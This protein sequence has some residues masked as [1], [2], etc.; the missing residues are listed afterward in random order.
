MILV[1]PSN[2]GYS[3]ILKSIFLLLN[4]NNLLD[5]SVPKACLNQVVFHS[6][7]KK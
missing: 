1:V 3:V 6:L 4:L 7:L 2:V 5:I